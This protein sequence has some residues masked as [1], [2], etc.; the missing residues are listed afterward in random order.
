MGGGVQANAQAGCPINA[1][2]HGTRGPFAVG[3]SDMDE[4]QL[5]MRI[6]RQLGQLERILQTEFRPEPTKTEKELDGIGVGQGVKKCVPRT[7][8]IQRSAD[9][10]SAVSPNCI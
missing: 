7:L 8:C 3:A 9:L 4:T 2:D 5:P 1:L 6:A 10:Q